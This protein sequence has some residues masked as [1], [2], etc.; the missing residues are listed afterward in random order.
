MGEIRAVYYENIVRARTYNGRLRKEY[1]DKHITED[2]FNFALG[3][4]YDEDDF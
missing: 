2:M 4:D 1:G 3:D